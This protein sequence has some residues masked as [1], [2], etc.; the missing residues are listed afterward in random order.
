MITFFFYL[1]VNM[2]SRRERVEVGVVKVRLYETKEMDHSQLFRYVSGYKIG[3]GEGVCVF[4][5]CDV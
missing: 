3:Q 4:H 1:C 5:Y 2:W